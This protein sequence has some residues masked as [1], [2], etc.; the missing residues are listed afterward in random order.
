[1]FLQLMVKAVEGMKSPICHSSGW[2]YGEFLLPGGA[3][4][5]PR[6]AH[7]L[8][9]ICTWRAAAFDS[10]QILPPWCHYGHYGHFDPTT[11]SHPMS[12][13]LKKT[14]QQHRTSSIPAVYQ[15]YT[16]SIPASCSAA[17]WIDHP[18]HGFK[19]LAHRSDANL[20]GRL[21]LVQRA[22][23]R[24]L[25]RPW[26][27]GWIGCPVGTHAMVRHGIPWNPVMWG[28]WDPTWSNMIQS[29]NSCGKIG[30]NLDWE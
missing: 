2:Y 25:L 17:R 5:D 24:L 3:V 21:A 22:E 19:L 23:P 27:F 14:P 7:L 18:G 10:F 13:T 6:R 26:C 1:M 20:E 16:S 30:S 4:W 15:Q 12:L 29:T 9:F 8:C 28:S 11:M